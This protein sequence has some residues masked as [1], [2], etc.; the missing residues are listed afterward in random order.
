MHG[1]F[2]Y[3]VTVL[4]KTVKEWQYIVENNP[5]LTGGREEDIRQ[6]I[7]YIINRGAFYGGGAKNCQFS[8]QG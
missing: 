1:T 4:V 3:D 2:G 5:Y 7:C 8:I 6:V